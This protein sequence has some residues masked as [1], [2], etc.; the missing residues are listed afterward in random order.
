M[1]KL[2]NSIMKTKDFF[3]LSTIEMQI[4]VLENDAY[5][6]ACKAK[7][8]FAISGATELYEMYQSQSYKLL[9]EIKELNN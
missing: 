2:K 4:E 9:K 6:F 3:K 5:S 1:L 7:N 8:E